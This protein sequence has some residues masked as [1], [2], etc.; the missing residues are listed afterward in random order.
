MPKWLS[1][2]PTKSTHVMPSETPPI[3]TRPSRMP[4]VMA[5][6]NVRTAWAMPLPKKRE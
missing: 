4:A 2:M 1:A 3:F 6:A 5:N